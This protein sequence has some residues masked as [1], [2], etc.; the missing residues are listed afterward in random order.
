[1]VRNGSNQIGQLH[2]KKNDALRE[3]LP[4]AGGVMWAP[5]LGAGTGDSAVNFQFDHLFG[6]GSFAPNITLI[7]QTPRY[8]YAD[9]ISWTRGKHAFKTGA[10][11]RIGSSKSTWTGTSGTGGAF[12]NV[13]TVPGVHGGELILSPVT[14]INSRNIPGLAGDATRGNQDRMEN[15]LVFLSGSV[16]RVSQFRYINR[17]DQAQKEWNDPIKEPVRIRDIFQREWSFFFKDDWKVSNRLTL[18]LGVRWDYYGPPWEK[19]G[20][21]ATLRGNGDALFG[22]SGRSFADWMRPG[23]RG[24]S[25]VWCPGSDRRSR[26]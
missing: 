12:N 15:L 14:G 19:S 1:M 11:F 6:G 26:A 18:N 16:G 3:L 21:T 22:I 23:T 2:D 20:L 7:D 9:T 4:K 5:Y 17:P 25:E 10:E 24:D 8:S 13:D